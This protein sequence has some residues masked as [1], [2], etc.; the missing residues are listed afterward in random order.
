MKYYSDKRDK[1]MQSNLFGLH[2]VDDGWQRIVDPKVE[3]RV[4]V[5]DRWICFLF[6]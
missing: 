3:G 2:N 6:V 4:K 1:G 5:E